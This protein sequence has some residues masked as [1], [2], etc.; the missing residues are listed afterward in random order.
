MTMRSAAAGP[1]RPG[2]GAVLIV[3][4]GVW[5]GFWGVWSALLPAVLEHDHTTPADLGLVLAA[6]P[7]GA[8]P[9]MAIAG[10]L[11]AGRES[12]ALAAALAVMAVAAALLGLVPGLVG[13]SIALL[14]LGA[15]SGG[16][17]VC[18]NMAI[19]RHERT[20]GVR[21]FQRAHAA[22]PVAQIVAAPAAG[23]GRQ[24]GLPLPVILAAPAAS[25]AAVGVL[26]VGLGAGPR[27]RAEPEPASGPRPRPADRGLRRALM[28]W[29]MALGA[30]GGTAL[31]IDNATEHWSVLLLQTAHGAPPVLASMAPS[32]FMASM[33]VGRLVAQKVP[34]IRIHHLLYAAAVAGCGGMAL[35]ASA[36][37]TWGSL[38]GFAVSGLTVGPVMPALLGH[39]GRQDASGVLVSIV[40]A[41]SY[42]GFVISPALIGT[43]SRW[44]PLPDA[45]T[46]LAVLALP[47]A[48]AAVGSRLPALARWTAPPGGAPAPARGALVPR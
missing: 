30:L 20:A 22:F 36:P 34:A 8:I 37:T 4:S 33:T 32:V 15:A 43:L 47:L 2:D 6:V 19:A 5:G 12:R 39:A 3:V 23:L 46:C 48:A 21:L 10:R 14:L 40:S 38:L 35:A 44:M 29:G 26:A 13:L 7:I 16:V 24:L 31:I 42:G 17:D 41:T 18:M 27:S 45:L 25:L 9:A 28:L 1:R 11:A